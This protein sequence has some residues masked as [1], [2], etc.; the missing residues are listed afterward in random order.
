LAIF[1]SSRSN[2]RVLLYIF[3]KY[4]NRSTNIIT[5]N[6]EYTIDPNNS[7]EETTLYYFQTLE[8]G[9]H[10]TMDPLM[11]GILSCSHITHGDEIVTS[12]ITEFLLCA[13]ELEIRHWLHLYTSLA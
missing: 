11:V 9:K 1:I 4:L 7:I 3:V 5:T 8:V 10:H 12:N 2:H 13:T 6:T